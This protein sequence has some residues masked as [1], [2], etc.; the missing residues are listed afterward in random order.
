[1][2]KK[3]CVSAVTVGLFWLLAYL[4]V[5]AAGPEFT[6]W[7]Y[8]TLGS[9]NGP[10][11]PETVVSVHCNTIVGNSQSGTPPGYPGIDGYYEIV[12]TRVA[13]KLRI[14]LEMPD[15]MEVAGNSSVRPCGPWGVNLLVCDI[16]P[17]QVKYSIGPIDFFVRYLIQ[18]TPTATTVPTATKPAVTPSV[19]PTSTTVPTETPYLMPTAIPEGRPTPDSFLACRQRELEHQV[20][21]N[22]I[23]R[24]IAYI[25]ASAV[26]GLGYSTLKSKGS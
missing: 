22:S 17:G 4:S 16:P 2:L 9:E 12:F 5:E 14:Y 25:L 24:Y 6:V 20:E 19:T 23:L 21:F 3:R 18:P 10:P 11:V 26:V 15:D 8:V 13:E 7:G 1:M